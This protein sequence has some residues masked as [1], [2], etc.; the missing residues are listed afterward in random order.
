MVVELVLGLGNPG[1][2]YAATRH[3]VGFRVLDELVCRAGSPA[4][5]ELSLCALTTLTLGRDVVIAKPLTYMNRSGAALAWLLERYLLVPSSVLVVVDDLDLPLGRLRVRRR[6]GPGTHNGLRDLCDAVGTDFPRLR[7]GVG[8]G[9]APADLADWVTSPFE[10]DEL[11]AAADAIER[12]ADAVEA[13]VADGIQ[14]AM[15]RFNR[16]D[17]AEPEPGGREPG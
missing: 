14:G 17:A 4:W 16:A 6:G 3:N 11:A 1:P 15:N 10:P 9:A 7:V 13:V 12:A 5:Q 2:R 8:T